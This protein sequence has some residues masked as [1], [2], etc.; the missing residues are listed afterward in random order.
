MYENL[1]NE[2]QVYKRQLVGIEEVKRDRDERIKVLRTE[3][4][5][6]TTKH[7]QLE[8]DHAKICVKYKSLF[9]SNTNLQRDYNN[10]N[11]NL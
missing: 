3:L 8:K 6:L 1:F 11:E 5:E 4:E 7:E 9:D 10:L 2:A